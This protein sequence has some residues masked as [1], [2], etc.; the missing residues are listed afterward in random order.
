MTFAEL[1]LSMRDEG[2]ACLDANEHYARPDAFELRVDTLAKD[3]LK[4]L[5]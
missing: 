3:G 4:W 5:N 2:L 1:D